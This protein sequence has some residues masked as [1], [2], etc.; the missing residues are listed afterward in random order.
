[1]R[2]NSPGQRHEP[3]DRRDEVRAPLRALPRRGSRRG[4]PRRSR[5]ASSRALGP[6]RI[7]FRLSGV[8][9]RI[10]G[11][12]ASMRRRSAAGV[13]PLRVRARMRGKALPGLAEARLQR[14]ERREEVALDVRVQ[15][16]QRRD[17]QDADL[18]RGP[19]ACRPA[20]RS[21]R[22]TRQGSCPFPWARRRAR[23]RR[24]RWPATPSPAPPWARPRTVGNH[25][26]I[27]GWKREREPG[28]FSA[29]CPDH[30][31]GSRTDGSDLRR[32]FQST[33]ISAGFRADCEESDAASFSALVMRSSMGE[34]GSR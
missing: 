12:F 5:R 26:R 14:R 3:L 19:G 10:S 27:R 24:A 29:M 21:P 22:E 32:D 1:M 9:M 11:G 31:A 17:V 18:A 16:L 4:S 8:V 7:R 2:W 30:C 13:S 6:A 23:D 28:A 33:A 15:R 20:C 34:C 25:E